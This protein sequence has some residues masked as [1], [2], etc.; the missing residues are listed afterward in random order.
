MQNVNFSNAIATGVKLSAGALQVKNC[1]SFSKDIFE[2]KLKSAA[3]MSSKTQSYGSVQDGHSSDV[4]RDTLTDARSIDRQSPS[5]AGE[6]S[7]NQSDVEEP[8]SAVAEEKLTLAAKKVMDSIE[9][10]LD[11]SEDDLLSAMEN[12]G[13]TAIDLFNPS[14]LANLVTELKGD[15]DSLG[16][17]MSDDFSI[18][19]GVAN[20]ALLQLLDET[21]ATLENMQIAD[22][23][24]APQI[25]L[26]VDETSM[27]AAADFNE[28]LP[29]KEAPLTGLSVDTSP[30]ENKADMILGHKLTE[31]ALEANRTDLGDNSNA[32]TGQDSSESAESVIRLDENAAIINSKD[33]IGFN[34]FATGLEASF[35]PANQVVELPTGETVHAKEILNQL[36]EQ[37]VVFSTSEEV[38]MELTLNPE[39][40]GKIFM[41]VT[42]KGNEVTARI[43]TENEAVKDALENQMASLRAGLNENTEK[44]TSVEISVATHEFERNLEEGQRQNDNQKHQQDDSSSQRQPIRIDLNNP[45]DLMGVMTKE[46]TLIAQIMKDNGN[47]I[48]FQA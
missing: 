18:I 27:D 16:L 20:E 3:E 44:I 47:T 15:T 19:L 32:F 14:Q 23:K 26:L 37:A 34:S 7:Q 43:F 5:K 21:G 40:L 8:D 38:T 31:G 35:N 1:D 42:Q 6:L 33:D 2:S 22:S 13:L 10:E 41:E 36:V 4:K 39:G 46:E 24:K 9:K 12:L 45:D 29:T 25:D 48:N 30:S 28:P 17:I 11:I